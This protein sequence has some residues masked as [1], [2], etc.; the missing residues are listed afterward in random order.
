MSARSGRYLAKTMRRCSPCSYEIYETAPDWRAW[1]T[2]TYGV[3]AHVPDL[4]T[5]SDT[6]SL[7][8]DLAQARKVFTTIAPIASP[9]D[10]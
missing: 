4:R 2:R 10:T 5:M 8:V 3:V 6:P 7:S 9:C 1:L